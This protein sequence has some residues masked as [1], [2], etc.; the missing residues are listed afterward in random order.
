M[1][2]N[3]FIEQAFILTKIYWFW[4]SCL[5]QRSDDVMP[6]LSC[7]SK[8]STSNR[9]LPPAVP[10]VRHLICILEQ[11]FLWFLSAWAERKKRSENLWVTFP[12]GCV[13]EVEGLPPPAIFDE[14]VPRTPASLDWIYSCR[15]EIHVPGIKWKAFPKRWANAETKDFPLRSPLLPLFRW[16]PP[17]RNK[18]VPDSYM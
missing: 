12:V 13:P 5:F 3:G 9:D 14:R 8:P 18:L 4:V 7:F 10:S 6:G 1:R 16:H 15:I 17:A 2:P 11:T